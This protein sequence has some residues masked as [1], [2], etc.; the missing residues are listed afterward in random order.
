MGY[1]DQARRGSGELR[2]VKI[3]RRTFVPMSVIDRFI[4]RD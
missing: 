3:G 2:T 1:S 4:D